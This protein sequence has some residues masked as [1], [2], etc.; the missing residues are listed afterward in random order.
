MA[1]NPDELAI[2]PMAQ[3]DPE[4]FEIARVWIAMKNQHC[5]LKVGVWDD[6]TAWGILLADL[7]RHVAKAYHED[8]GLDEEETLIRIQEGF[9]AEFDSP[10]DTPTGQIA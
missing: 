7:A 5:T 4:S 10:T 9:A 2:P 6:P 8:K 1:P 3:E